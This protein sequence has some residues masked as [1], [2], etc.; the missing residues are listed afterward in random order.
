MLFYVGMLCSSKKNK[1][2]DD[3]WQVEVKV[4]LAANNNTVTG[5]KKKLRGGRE[6]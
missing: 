2:Y 1:K 4:V 3:G 6:K 5:N